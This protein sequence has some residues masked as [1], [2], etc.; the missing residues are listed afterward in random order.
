[1]NKN[2]EI[3]SVD[4]FTKS[5]DRL[6][7]CRLHRRI[8]EDNDWSQHATMLD[9]IEDYREVI[10]S[11]LTP[12]E[13]TVVVMQEPYQQ[14]IDESVINKLTDRIIATMKK[15]YTEDIDGGIGVD[16]IGRDAGLLVPLGGGG[17]AP[18][19]EP[20]KLDDPAIPKTLSQE[21]YDQLRNSVEIL[22]TMGAETEASL[23]ETFLSSVEVI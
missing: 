18:L 2:I 12:V 7:S 22:K 3:D 10:K 14:E 15:K 16:D 9:Y 20:P 1:M 23:L 11:Q 13:E 4:K 6:K 19:V 5:V 8:N 17:Q 21:S